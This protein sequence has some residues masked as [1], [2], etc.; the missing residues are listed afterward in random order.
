MQYDSKKVANTIIAMAIAQG[1]EVNSIKLQKLLYY[2]H[3]W[4]LA[5]SKMPLLDE[6]IAAKE[7]GIVIPSVY[8][9]L[10]Q[11][12]ME[13]LTSLFQ[14]FDPGS[15]EW[16]EPLIESDKA[17]RDLLERVL[18]IYAHLTTIELSN[19]THHRDSPWAESRRLK[20]SSIKDSQ[21]TSFFASIVI[22]KNSRET[23]SF[24]NISINDIR[25]EATQLNN[26]PDKISL[27]ELSEYE[28]SSRDT[29]FD[30]PKRKWKRVTKHRFSWDSDR[31]Q[32]YIKLHLEDDVEYEL[33]VT[34][35]RELKAILNIFRHEERVH[36]NIISG[37]LASGWKLTEEGRKAHKSRAR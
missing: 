28:R 37:T 25:R 9:S 22:D 16:V 27:L 8:Y 35:P 30:A 20:R 15:S 1:C 33:G 18:E 6:E 31:M 26:R 2:A 29:Q 3:G 21:L 4:H 11:T 7:F 10:R 17:V 13:P 34:T 5:I 36:Y 24:F 19:L 14:E 23:Q 12:G 32:G